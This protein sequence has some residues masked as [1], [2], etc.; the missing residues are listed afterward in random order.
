MML[1]SRI[2]FREAV[3]ARDKHI[4]VFCDNPAVDAHHIIE[5]RLWSDYGYYLDNGASV[6]GAHHIMCEETTISVE[7]V[8]IA[9]GIT[10]AKCI[11]SHLYPDQPYDKWGNPVR[12]NGRRF[13]GELF[14]D[15]SVQKILKQGRVLDLF[16]KYVKYP[17]T[18]HF[19]WSESITDDDRILT[20]LSGFENKEVVVTIKMDGE[21]TTM[22][23]DHIHA[24]S[25]DSRNHVSRNWV[26]N[27]H[28]KISWEIPEGWRICG[29]NLWAE[30]AINYNNLDSFFMG[31]S[32]WD[33][34]N[35]CLDWD[36]TV[37]FLNILDI[38]PVTVIYRGVFDK[39]KIHDTFTNNFSTDNTEG[40]VVRTVEKFH[41]K[42]FK[43]HVGKFVRKEH[44]QNQKHWF[45]G[46]E[47]KL[48]KMRKEDG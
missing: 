39:E 20:D 16:D 36:D 6:C 14:Q 31:F 24:R 3:F 34:N 38:T 15:E 2:E 25:L 7:E 11:P 23:D 45:F 4:C 44:V 10:H 5:R 19:D 46:A 48:N 29:E 37:E 40:Y 41:Y 1:L 30:H 28:S 43:K 22:Y 8:R 21:N 42:N 35:E 17:R 27:F 13:K 47:I 26:K 18:Y 32:I 9:C 33:E 12:E